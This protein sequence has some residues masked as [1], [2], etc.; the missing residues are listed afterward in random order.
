MDKDGEWSQWVL[1][2]G[3]VEVLGANAHVAQTYSST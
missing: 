3:V 1:A 2:N